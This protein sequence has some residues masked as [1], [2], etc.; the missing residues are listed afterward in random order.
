MN[1]LM[2]RLRAQIGNIGSG[3]SRVVGNIRR[4]ASP[5]QARTS[6]S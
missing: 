5:A 2:G 3:I 4:A 1:T 6:G